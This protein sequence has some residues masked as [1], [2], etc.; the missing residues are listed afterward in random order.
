MIGA[1]NAFD[2]CRDRRCIVA[3]V[4]CL[5]LA[6]L[7][8]AAS[9]EVHAQDAGTELLD[10]ALDLHI[11]G[12]WREAFQRYE[13][14]IKA[15]EATEDRESILVAA[16]NS[17]GLAAN[18]GRYDK[19][20]SL[21]RRSLEMAMHL[22]DREA[23]ATSLNNLGLACRYLGRLD[24]ALEHYSGA[25]ALNRA[26]GDMERSVRALNNIG[27]VHFN[28]GRFGLA[29][30]VHQE[31][32][33]ISRREQAQWSTVQL[34]IARANLGAVLEKTGQVE[35]AF[36]LYRNVLEDTEIP[37]D[38]EAQ[39]RTSLG[40]CY[41]ELEDP[42]QALSCYGRARDLFGELGDD[43][44]V[45]NVALHIGATHCRGLRRH[46]EAQAKY[47]E[48]LGIAVRLGDAVEALFSRIYLARCLL[49]SGDADGALGQFEIARAEAREMGSKEGLWSALQGAGRALEAKGDSSLA[50]AAFSECLDLLDE[51]RETDIA[52]DFRAGFFEDKRDVACAAV[53]LIL[54]MDAGSGGARQEAVARAFATAERHRAR[55]LLDR[56]KGRVREL[57]EI[58]ANTLLP[59]EALVEFVASGDDMVAFVV[60]RGEEAKVIE[61]DGVVG[62]DRLVQRLRRE[63]SG[64]EVSGGEAP[65]DG[66][67]ATVSGLL[68]E[69][70]V[71]PITSGLPDSVRHLVIVTD[72]DLA[73]VPFAALRMD[74]SPDAPHVIERYG[75][76]YVP[77][78]AVLASLRE[79]AVNRSA[80]RLAAFGD[81]D[82]PDLTSVRTSVE[83]ATPFEL[84]VAS[85][86]LE[87]LPGS[88]DEVESIAR[89]IGGNR[90]VRCGPAATIE[91]LRETLVQRPRILHLATHAVVD[92]SKPDASALLFTRDT[93]RDTSVVE[94]G[95]LRPAELRDLDVPAELVTLS[96]CRSARGRWI[97]GEGVI[98]LARSFIEAGSR[99]VVA[100]SFRVGDE[101]SAW[102]MKRFYGHISAGL[103][104]RD[105]LR[106]T[107]L[108]CLRAPG[109]DASVWAP[110]VIVGD[111]SHPIVD[112]PIGRRLL[113]A[114]LVGL[115]V[116]LVVALA[117]LA[118]QRMTA[119]AAA[120]GR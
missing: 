49:H 54:R 91:N 42:H 86:G 119:V 94:G 118:R 98:G 10:Q 71:A 47:E 37:A 40:R 28:A 21:A 11:A 110:Y 116:A 46:V 84:L 81:P 100:T 9:T 87:R 51:V 82:M 61:M 72:G 59:G 43:G 74:G 68:S 31:A 27:V 22:D 62:L 111:G 78:A 107:Q 77:S 97:A 70:F 114:L 56:L 32:A 76:S 33:A 4:Q 29:F 25:L 96:A 73:Q 50:L 16:L 89:R 1:G 95:L 115:A 48:A 106:Q 92:E 117:L 104:P 14:A 19:A 105:A 2:V 99:A 12:N 80:M 63:V 55:S 41:Y 101:Q 18:L 7:L 44:A 17:A 57:D 120:S 24:E 90:V 108:A 102:F 85:H 3:S 13:D 66:H 23:E 65:L 15:L 39:I 52:V 45:G 69:A 5:V 35:D 113:I 112:V 58:Q 36:R 30:E 34:H 83:E 88:V 64:R 53:R 67:H 103:P 26:L 109:V 79:R 75:V 8:L 38:L 93:S 60:V 6:A 20:E